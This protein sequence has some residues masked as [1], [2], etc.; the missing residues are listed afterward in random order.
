MKILIC[1]DNKLASKTL[2]VVIRKEGYLTETAVDGNDAIELLR[3]NIYDL[4]IMDIH[5]PF[6][7][8]L[9][10]VRYMRIDLKSKTPVLIVTAFSDPQMQSQANELGIS[11]YIVKP[12]NPADLLKQIREI[13][14]K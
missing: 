1:E 3:K 2:E 5:L 13:L 8:G 12:F 4:V 6:H 14:M 9:E 7:S 11:G 10:L